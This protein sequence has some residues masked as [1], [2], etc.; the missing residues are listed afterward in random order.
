MPR[1]T[2]ADRIAREHKLQREAQARKE[3]DEAINRKIALVEAHVD[4]I[5]TIIPFVL[6]M[7]ADLGYPDMTEVNIAEKVPW[8]LPGGEYNAMYGGRVRYHLKAAWMIAEFAVRS[9]GEFLHGK[10][11]LFS[12][13]RICVDYFG[14]LVMSLQEL[15]EYSLKIEVYQLDELT[16]SGLRKLQIKLET[17]LKK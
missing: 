3:Q 8:Y 16:V 12:D 13:G 9:K 14:Q 2:E 1:E 7:L 5:S 6:Q 17:M 10:I 4:E 11:Y 15:R